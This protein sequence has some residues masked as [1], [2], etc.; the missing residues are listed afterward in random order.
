LPAVF[1]GLVHSPRVPLTGVGVG[2]SPECC[3]QTPLGLALFTFTLWRVC[4]DTDRR[5]GADG[6]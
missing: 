4:G 5:A 2:E 3:E 1:S 6:M